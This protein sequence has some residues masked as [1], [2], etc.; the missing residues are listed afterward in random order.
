M[1]TKNKKQ[2]EKNWKMNE[3]IAY[4]SSKCNQAKMIKRYRKM[5]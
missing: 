1:K 3:N 2:S 5:L 4:G